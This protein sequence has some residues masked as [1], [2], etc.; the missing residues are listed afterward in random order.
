MARVFSTREN[1]SRSCS[2]PLERFIYRVSGINKDEST[3]GK[4]NVV[5]DAAL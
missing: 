3:T 5:A 4:E 1:I 2:R